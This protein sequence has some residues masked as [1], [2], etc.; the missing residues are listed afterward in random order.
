[1]H[2][3][4]QSTAQSILLFFQVVMRLQVQP[5]PFRSSK[6][7]GQAQ[8]RIDADRTLPANDFVDP[9]GRNARVFREP[10]LAYAERGK[11]F[12]LQ[13]FAGMYGR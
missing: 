7:A 8:C 1:M 12:F 3:A 13:Y 9:T 11:E 10:I 4:F 2:F 6:E 5:E